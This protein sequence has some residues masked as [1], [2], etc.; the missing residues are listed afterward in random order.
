MG[1]KNRLAETEVSELNIEIAAELLTE[2]DPA[3]VLSKILVY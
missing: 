3:E 1:R 2:K